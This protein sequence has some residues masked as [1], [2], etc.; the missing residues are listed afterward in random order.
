M[1]EIDRIR[2]EYQRRAREI[3]ADLYLPTNLANLFL[4]QQRA[5]AVLTAFRKEQFLPL[6]GK[7]ILEIGCGSCGWLPALEDWGASRQDL[8][9]ID[10]DAQRLDRARRRLSAHWDEQG[11]LLSPGADLRCGDAAELPWEDNTFDLVLQ[12][13]VLTSILDPAMKQAAA[14]E[15]MRVVKPEGIILWYDFRYD[16]PCN[17]HVR[18][19]GGRELRSLFPKTQIH[20]R[21][22]TL[23]PLLARRMVPWT[24][25][26]AMML[27][28][29]RFLNTHYLGIIRKKIVF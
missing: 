3:A 9:G 18:G 1:N 7:K 2:Q 20:L 17:P 10:L 4:L 13:T 26:G 29:F 25:L 14:F 27:E 21:R 15:M 24:W 22:I 28:H 16:N 5:R 6:H 11:R 23:A 8:A 19:I 12:S